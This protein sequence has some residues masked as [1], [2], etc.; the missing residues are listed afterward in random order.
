MGLVSAIYFNGLLLAAAIEDMRH[1]RIPNRLCLLLGIG[2]LLLDLPASWGE[3]AARLAAL[4]VIGAGG[5]LLYLLRVLGGGDYKLLV[6]CAVWIPLG[7][8]PVFGVLLAAI[9]GLQ[10]LA[11]L[12]YARVGPAAGWPPVNIRH[13][14]YAVSI[15]ASGLAWT[16]ALGAP[17]WPLG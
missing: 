15:A 3:A 1:L 2:G 7:Q 10:A 8:A 13:M 6:A 12:A 4:G 16:L 11:T 9:G 14:P 5:L 17:S